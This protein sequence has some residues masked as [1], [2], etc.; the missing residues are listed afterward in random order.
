MIHDTLA[1]F[2]ERAAALYTCTVIAAEAFIPG[3]S[4]G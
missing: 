1:G 3:G 2:Y 4:G